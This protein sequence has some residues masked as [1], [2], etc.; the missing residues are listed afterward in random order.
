MLKYSIQKRILRE[1]SQNAKQ[2]NKKVGSME[3]SLDYYKNLRIYKDKTTVELMNA[4]M[5][6]NL[7]KLDKIVDNGELL[8]NFSSKII[9]KI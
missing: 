5:V 7:C 8:Y 4:K 9:G 6:W 1:F 3:W 2:I